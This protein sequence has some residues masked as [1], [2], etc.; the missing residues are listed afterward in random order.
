MSCVLFNLQIFQKIESDK[1]LNQIRALLSS[2][3]HHAG[4]KDLNEW[5]EKHRVQQSGL[6]TLFWI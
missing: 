5:Y 6:P 1:P 4:R 2:S 3:I